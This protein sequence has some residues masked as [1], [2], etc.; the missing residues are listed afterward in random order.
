MPFFGHTLP[1]QEHP[2]T[3]THKHTHSNTRT[4]THKAPTKTVNSRTRFAQCARFAHRMLKNN[5]RSGTKFRYAHA[6]SQKKTP[7]TVNS[8]TQFLRCAY[9]HEHTDMHSQI[10]A[11]N[12]EFANSIRTTRTLRAQHA[13]KTPPTAVRN[14]AEVEVPDLGV[15]TFA[16]RVSVSTWRP[17]SRYEHVG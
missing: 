5:I 15:E 12:G 7:T 6:P 2:H 3:C 9:S 11:H 13:Q 1:V 16:G 8:Q 14:F 4:R 10:T 17:R